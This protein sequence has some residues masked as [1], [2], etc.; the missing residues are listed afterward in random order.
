MSC[1]QNHEAISEAKTQNSMMPM[2][3][4]EIASAVNGTVHVSNQNNSSNTKQENI[5]ATSVF[6]DSREIREGSVFVAIAGEHVD[7][8]DYVENAEKSGAVLAI[9]EHFVK[10]VYITQIVVKNSVEA[11]GLLAKHNL[12]R[13]RELQQPFTIVGITGSVGKT[14][15]KDMLKSLLSTLGET[16]APVGSFN[17][18]IGLPLTSLKVGPSTRFLVAEMGANHVGEI[19]NL[20]KIAPPDIA[21]VL[22]VGVAHLGEFGSVERIAQAKSEIVQGLVPHGIAVL[23]ADD[24]RVFAMSNLADKDHVRYFGRNLKN[25]LLESAPKSEYQLCASCVELDSFGKPTF[26]LSE[27]EKSSEK[28]SEDS[29]ECTN[30]TQVHL[31]IQGEHNVMNA[32]AAANVARYFGMPLENIA[33]VL[34]KVSHISPHRMQL[35]TVSYDGK[36][37]MLIDDSFNANPDSMKAGLDGLCAYESKDNAKK[38]N[39]FRIAVLGSMLELGKNECEL[40]ENIGSYAAKSNVDAVIAVGSKTDSDLDNLAQC[41]VDGARNSWENKKLSAND[42]VH[43]AHSSYEANELV[44]KIVADHPSSVVLLKGSHASGLSVLAER[45]AS[46]NK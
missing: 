1:D 28:S 15:T 37:F 4:F 38:S 29:S 45:W 30:K 2:S 46:I 21:V 20:T 25:G 22:K 13:R 27:Y 10:D 32:L 23:N 8:H 12:Q 41:I 18:E 40:H 44:W 19:A 34:G 31:A 35:S 42:A 7:G 3:V 5:T 16:V 39:V 33:D 6:T 36:E 11:L 14:T 9:V 17:N 43:L 24:F 26:T